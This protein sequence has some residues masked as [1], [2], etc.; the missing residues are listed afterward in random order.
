[1]YQLCERVQSPLLGN[2]PEERVMFHTSARA[3]NWNI[4]D[5]I[6]LS[7]IDMQRQITITRP[8]SS[9]IGMCAT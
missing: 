3:D 6:E 8:N 2:T 5:V 4:T 7:D 9:A 1:M